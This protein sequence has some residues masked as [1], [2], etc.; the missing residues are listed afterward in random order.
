VQKKFAT[1]YRVAGGECELEI[2]PGCEHQWVRK[3]GPQT[4]RAIEMIKTFIAHRL[5]VLR[6]AA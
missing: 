3:P 6:Q 1:S 2:F 5:K 4:D